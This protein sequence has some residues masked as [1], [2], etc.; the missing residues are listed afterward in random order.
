MDRIRPFVVHQAVSIVSY[1]VCG[2]SLKFLWGW[3]I[4]TTFGLSAITPIQAI[5]MVI[6]VG[7]LVEQ[8]RPAVENKSEVW[9]S[10]LD[11]AYFKIFLGIVSFIYG[12]I[13]H[14]FM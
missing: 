13:I 12:C 2:F 6:V 5:G 14:L 1:V 8:Y 10:A 9:K 4:V 7:L 3:F 11:A